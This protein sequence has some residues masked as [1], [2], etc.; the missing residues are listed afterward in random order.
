MNIPTTFLQTARRWAVGPA[1]VSNGETLTI[2]AAGRS[3]DLTED[4]FIAIPE[5]DLSRMVAAADPLAA[6][7]DYIGSAGVLPPGVETLIH[8]VLPHRY[9][10]HVRTSLVAG[11]LAGKESRSHTDRLFG[12]KALWLP[13]TPPN[14]NLLK[15]VQDL[16]EGEDTPATILFMQN[17]GLLVGADT[18]EELEARCKEVEET[19]RHALVRTPELTPHRQDSYDLTELGDAVKRA[20]ADMRAALGSALDPPLTTACHSPE[21]LRRAASLEDFGPVSSA[22]MSDHLA[23]L[24]RKLCFVTRHKELTSPQA[25]LA[26]VLHEMHDFYDTHDAAPRVVVVEG[27]GAVIVGDTEEELSSA[28]TAFNAALE[29]ACYAESFG[30]ARSIPGE[31]VDELSRSE[32]LFFPSGEAT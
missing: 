30:G 29:T 17:H 4:D 24:G 2:T 18:P 26:D 23:H 25:L 14:N 10:V 7:F 22:L 8:F 3:S 13:V 9:I 12:G 16:L 27:S 11:L 1:S 32:R 15:A 28:C 21:I 31:Y 19:I 20:L 5:S 6:L